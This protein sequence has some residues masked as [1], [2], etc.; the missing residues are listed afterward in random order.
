MQ[1]VHGRCE[2]VSPDSLNIFGRTIRRQRRLER[3][4]NTRISTSIGYLQSFLPVACL[5]VDNALL[6]VL[7]RACDR[8]K[9]TKLVH[10]MAEQ[11]ANALAVMRPS[12]SLSKHRRNIDR[13]QLA[14]LVLA[15]LP[16]F[17]R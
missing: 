17:L 11:I 5:D 3:P 6:I 16:P 15:V 9:L 13:F 7:C 12:D 4:F 2:H 1:P 8:P 10:T 14:A